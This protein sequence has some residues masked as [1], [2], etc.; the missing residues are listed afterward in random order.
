MKIQNTKLI[1]FMF[2]CL[3]PIFGVFFIVPTNQLEWYDNNE[4]LYHLWYVPTLILSIILLV[5]YYIGTI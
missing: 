4:I 2:L 5:G 1:I 3:I